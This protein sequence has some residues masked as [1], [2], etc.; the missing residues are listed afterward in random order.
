MDDVAA[1]RVSGLTSDGLVSIALCRQDYPYIRLIVDTLGGEIYD[2]TAKLSDLISG[3]MV[4]PIRL[5]GAA[6]KLVR[7]LDAISLELNS[8][9]DQLRTEDSLIKGA[10]M[11]LRNKDGDGEESVELNS[12][13]VFLQ[14]DRRAVIKGGAEVS[15][16]SRELTVLSDTIGKAFENLLMQLVQLVRDE[17]VELTHRLNDDKH[18]LVF[19]DIQQFINSGATCSMSETLKHNDQLM[20]RYRISVARHEELTLRDFYLVN[21]LY[22]VAE[23]LPMSA[24]EEQVSILKDCKPQIEKAADQLVEHVTQLC[25]EVTRELDQKV[26]SVRQLCKEQGTRLTSEGGV[27]SVQAKQFRLTQVNELESGMSDTPHEQPKLQQ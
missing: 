13:E 14:Q 4:H 12:R 5:L 15:N 9:T 25:G 2:K 22:A 20:E 10:L 24:S 23:Q 18:N 21:L 17:A 6:V 3:A 8:W 26:E 19:G 7:E 11:S 27:L 1:S 16:V